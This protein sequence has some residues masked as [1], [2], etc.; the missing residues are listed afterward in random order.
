M[1][2]DAS[3]ALQAKLP[4]FDNPLAQLAQVSQIQNYQNQNRLADLAFGEK[5]REMEQ[6]NALSD[7]YRNALAP[8]GTIDR[9]KLYSSAASAGLG[10]KLPAIQK[11]FA[12]QDKAAADAFKQKLENGIK[13]IEFGAQVFSGV[14]DQASYDA[15]RQHVAQVLGPERAAQ[16]PAVYDPAT[17]QAN[18]MKALAVKDQLA[19]Q[20][21]ALEFGQKE[22]EFGERVRHNKATEGNAAGTLAVAQGN[23]GV[24]R[25]REAR[26]A[27]MPRGQVV[28]SDQGMMLVD[29]RTAQAQPVMANGQPLTPKLKDLPAPIQK[30]LLENNSALGKIDKALKAVDDYPDAFGP[31]NLMGDAIRQRTDPKGVTGR[32]LVADIGS[33]K[34]HDRSG[35]AVTASETPRLKPFVPTANDDPATIREKLKLFQQEYQAIQDDIAGTYTRDQGYKAPAQRVKDAVESGEVDKLAA[36]RPAQVKNAADYA[37]LPSGAVYTAPDGSMRTKK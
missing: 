17:I 4:Q 29:P 25:A 32:A 9:N 21:K 16:M 11:G 14:R 26:E 1:A 22:A 28:Q 10:A 35:A 6:A 36:S 2:I 33:L 8:D 15:A 24:N 13:E 30:T 31:M 7:A 3:I 12:D 19:E 23:L 20:W 37:K 18:R 34:I 5:Q 27:T